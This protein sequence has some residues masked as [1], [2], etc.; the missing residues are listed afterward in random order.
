[1]GQKKFSYVLFFFFFFVTSFK[2]LWGSEYKIFKLAIRKIWKKNKENPLK[3]MTSINK[4]IDV[5]ETVAAAFVITMGKRMCSYLYGNFS[6]NRILYLFESTFLEFGQISAI[7]F[8]KEFI[9]LTMVAV[10]IG[11]RQFL[12]YHSNGF[13]EDEKLHQKLE[14]YRFKLPLQKLAWLVQFTVR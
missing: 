12:S 5:F 9:S 2:K 11:K 3:Y 6:C 7:I 14:S 8:M 13:Y 4:K 10:K 1:M